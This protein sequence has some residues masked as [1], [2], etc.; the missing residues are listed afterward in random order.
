MIC[1]RVSR[2]RPALFSGASTLLH[3]FQILALHAVEIEILWYCRG[4]PINPVDPS[5]IGRYLVAT[6]EMT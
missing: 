4:L 6:S 5:G 3:P 2:P 1:N